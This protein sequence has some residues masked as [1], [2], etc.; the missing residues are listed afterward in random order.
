MGRRV[1][2][3]VLAA[4]TMAAGTLAATA[5]PAGAAVT[6]VVTPSTGLLDGHVV[7]VE[8]AGLTPGGAYFVAQCDAGP[9]ISC[10]P[11]PAEGRTWP[12][13]ARVTADTEGAVSTRLKLDRRNRCI[14][15]ECSVG[16]F[17]ASDDRTPLASAPLDFVAE[18]SY[19]W[20]DAT[21]TV[22]TTGPVLEASE[23]TVSATGLDPWYLRSGEPWA[24]V[25]LCRDDGA[26][27]PE[28]DCRAIT[29][30]D[31]DEEEV[32]A[33]IDVAPDGTGSTTFLLPRHIDVPGAFAYDC[34]AE[35]CGILVTQRT[36]F[37]DDAR[38]PQSNLVPLGYAA[39][40]VPWE[41]AEAFVEDALEPVRGAPMHGGADLIAAIEDRTLE[42][43]E[44]LL[45][46]GAS[47]DDPGS[48]NNQPANVFRLYWGFFGRAPE[49]GGLDYWV[50]RLRNG[51]TITSVARSF[52]GT[53]EFRAVYGTASDATVVD[54][55]YRNTLGREPDATGRAYWID[56]LKKG[57]ARSTLLLHFTRSPEMR[58]LL[59]G[60]TALTAITYTL[61]GRA[62]TTAELLLV[63]DE[64]GGIAL[65]PGSGPHELAALL[66][67]SGELLPH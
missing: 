16:L 22:A 55:A 23:V 44:L 15:L 33:G 1:V 58:N 50:R 25:M 28:V 27:D 36:P 60:P 45:G 63:T 34:A 38:E 7:A 8:A 48:T 49:D 9:G 61:A 3:A 43:P 54:R 53:P 66:I 51:A 59:M 12:S 64:D 67:A 46:A 42:A 65:S 26:L 35:G 41:S 32:V 40:W 29:D 30:I 47:S 31:L 39:E 52:G 4:L 20:P 13:V 21:A 5:A 57:M 24:M 56:R 10:D 37:H 14:D 2:A 11:M 62:P 17:A 19:A 6:L 18:G